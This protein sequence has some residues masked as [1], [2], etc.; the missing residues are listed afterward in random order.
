MTGMDRMT[1]RRGPS[2]QREQQE[3]EAA[4][5]E[6]AQCREEAPPRVGAA[7]RL[8]DHAV[9]RGPGCTP[10]PGRGTTEGPG[11]ESQPTGHLENRSGGSTENAGRV[12][13]PVWRGFLS[14]PRT[15]VAISSPFPVGSGLSEGAWVSDQGQKGRRG[16]ERG[17]WS[18]P[19]CRPEWAHGPPHPRGMP[20]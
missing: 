9:R 15:G 14:S 4:C 10:Q 5:S 6:Q 11:P 2:R 20:G 13:R 1:G 17:L 8:E 18:K 3:R 19:V 7:V 16:E 12:A